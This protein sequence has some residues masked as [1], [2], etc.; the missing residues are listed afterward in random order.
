MQMR[1]MW[2]WDSMLTAGQVTLQPGE[3]QCWKK[4]MLYLLKMRAKMQGI[5]QNGVQ[6]PPW[7]GMTAGEMQVQPRMEMLMKHLK[8]KKI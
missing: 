7:A 1:M 2:E 4:K 5:Q 3:V 6:Q 8:M